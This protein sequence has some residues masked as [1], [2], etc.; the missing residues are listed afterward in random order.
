MTVVQ[1]HAHRTNLSGRP[2]KKLS[3]LLE[4][5]LIKVYDGDV[6]QMADNYSEEKVAIAVR[7]LFKDGYIDRGEMYEKLIQWC[8]SKL[9][10]KLV[11]KA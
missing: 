2:E 7:Q 4:E 11:Q 9:T 10:S 1:L 5:V 6:L 3:K 8:A